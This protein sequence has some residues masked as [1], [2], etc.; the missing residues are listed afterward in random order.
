MACAP[1]SPTEEIARMLET[2]PANRQPDPSEP[3]GNRQG[4]AQPD[5]SGQSGT[6]TS[7]R[8]G[9]LRRTRRGA[10]KAADPPAF[11]SAGSDTQQ[12]ETGR[13]QSG[14]NADQAAG[15]GASAPVPVV[16]NVPPAAP[17]Q[18]RDQPRGSH[19]PVPPAAFQAPVVVFQPPDLTER[20]APATTGAGASP[21]AGPGAPAGPGPSGEADDDDSAGS[22]SRRRRRGGRGRGKGTTGDAATGSAPASGPGGQATSGPNAAS[23]DAAA[24]AA[25]QRK[26]GAEA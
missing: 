3:E 26:S 4:G 8:R 10:T 13:G 19:Q 17:A 2:E 6:E 16:P 7:Q 14:A 24:P 22:A 21:N 15:K 1:G 5:E 11:S 20:R 23:A 9:L 25:D 18:F 12:T